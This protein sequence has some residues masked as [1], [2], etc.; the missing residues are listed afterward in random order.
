M[1]TIEALIQKTEEEIATLQQEVEVLRRV[2]AKLHPEPKT[3]TK[4]TPKSSQDQP[5]PERPTIVSA[6]VSALASTSGIRRC[7]LVNALR[8][9]G[10]S[11][12]GT[13]KA[14][15]NLASR[16]IVEIRKQRD[17]SIVCLPNGNPS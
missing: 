6:V 17:V 13:Q 7:E 11:Y 3:T 14:I 8:K 4:K 12:E 9:D 5:P 16:G 10:Y 2:H 1:T 15:S